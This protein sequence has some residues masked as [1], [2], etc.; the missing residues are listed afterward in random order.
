MSDRFSFL[1]QLD[2]KDIIL[3]TASLILSALDYDK[4][5]FDPYIDIL[6][7]IGDEI[8]FVSSLSSGSD[9][10]AT[11]VDVI[12][13]KFGF[14]GKRAIGDSRL[15]AG[16]MPVID[17][18]EGPPTSLAIL[19]VSAARRMGWAADVVSLPPQIL[20]RVGPADHPRFID[21]ST[22][23][24]HASAPHLSG[25]PASRWLA[26]IVPANDNFIPISNRMVLVL[27]L[28]EEANSAERS[29]DYLRAMKLHERITI[30]APSHC[31]GWWNL[32]GMQTRL[33]HFDEARRSLWAVLEI[34][35]DAACRQI[36]ASALVRLGS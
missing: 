5:S 32:A 33:G 18:R 30:I 2:D 3:D 7:S 17:R 16:L 34:T 22:G 31:E 14:S 12:A 29:G 26:K 8:E 23:K 20:V 21:P 10:A 25:G 19:Y 24:I 13:Y 6:K 4:V 1:A 35:R 15:S 11:L 28:T 36:I 9:I 27:S